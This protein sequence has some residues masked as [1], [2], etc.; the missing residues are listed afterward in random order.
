M[1]KAYPPGMLF[2]TGWTLSIQNYPS[3][4]GAPRGSTSLETQCALTTKF[5]RGPATVPP[6]FPGPWRDVMGRRQAPHW[7]QRLGG[8]VPTPDSGFNR[9][10]YG[11]GTQWAAR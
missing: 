6:W 11:S 9:V 1:G 10:P 5:S 4:S 3:R 2:T 8:R 7:T